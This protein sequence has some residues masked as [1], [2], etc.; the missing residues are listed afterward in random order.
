M[1]GSSGSP[2]S[3]TIEDLN[4]QGGDG[5]AAVRDHR[6]FLPLGAK[7]LPLFCETDR[8]RLRWPDPTVANASLS[9]TLE[10]GFRDIC[11]FGV[12]PGSRV[13]EQRL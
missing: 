9:F 7:S 2:H 5:A 3:G 4:R 8:H 13:V 11:P 12:D 6:I 1:I 10:V